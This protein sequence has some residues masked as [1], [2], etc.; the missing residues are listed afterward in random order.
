MDAW[1]KKVESGEKWSQVKI[2]DRHFAKICKEWTD[3]QMEAKKRDTKYFKDIF[4][5]T[6]VNMMAPLPGGRVGGLASP[7]KKYK[8]AKKQLGRTKHTTRPVSESPQWDGRFTVRTERS[9]ELFCNKK[10]P[11]KLTQEE[12]NELAMLEIGETYADMNTTFPHKK[13]TNTGNTS[14]YGDTGYMAAIADDE[15]ECGSP[16]SVPAYPGLEDVES[17]SS[18]PSKLEGSKGSKSTSRGSVIKGYPDE[19]L[20]RTGAKLD[21]V[22]ATTK[23]ESTIDMTDV[24]IALHGKAPILT[25]AEAERQRRLAGEERFIAEAEQRRAAKNEA[26]SMTFDKLN[27][28]SSAGLCDFLDLV[29]FTHYTEKLFAQGVCGADLVACDEFALSRL[30]LSFRPHRLKMLKMLDK[31]RGQSGTTFRRTLTKTIIDSTLKNPFRAKPVSDGYEL[32]VRIVCVGVHVICD[33]WK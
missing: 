23:A 22:D 13:P 31:L 10:W 8:M 1:I 4:Y 26:A 12:E 16:K 28:L 5:R 19:S 2:S 24:F 9:T 18:P 15:D 11:K 20:L 30:G 25:E 17:R 33:I 32:Q 6:D 27:S 7:A 3:V 29:G 14:A 21:D